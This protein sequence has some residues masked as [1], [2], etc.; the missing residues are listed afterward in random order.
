MR[1]AA[2]CLTFILLT[3]APALA[4]QLAPG[5]DI[6]PGERSVTTGIAEASSLP[7]GAATRILFELHKEALEG[8]DPVIWARLTAKSWV[9][10]GRAIPMTAANPRKKTGELHCSF[11]R[12]GGN[13]DV[14][15]GANGGLR[16]TPAPMASGCVRAA[17]AA[18][19]MG[20]FAIRPEQV[21]GVVALAPVEDGQCRAAMEHF[22]KLLEE[23]ELRI[24]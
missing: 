13:L 17:P 2:F 24:D 3:V 9:P 6:K 12:D 1:T 23:E 7:P 11:S 8:Q 5:S 14:A 15:A 19:E 16:L 18:R 22:E 21:G 10:T 4:E 20:A